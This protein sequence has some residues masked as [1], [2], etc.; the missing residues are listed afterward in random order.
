MEESQILHILKIR[1]LH[2]K[3]IAASNM[4]GF[5]QHVNHHYQLQL[6]NYPELYQWSIDH[7]DQ[8]WPAVWDYCQIQAALPYTNPYQRAAATALFEDGKPT[9]IW[10]PGARLNFAENCLRFRDDHPAIIFV[11]EN[12]ERQE[13]SYAALYQQVAAVAQGLKN[14]GIEA[15]DCVAG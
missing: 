9:T 14:A 8:F 10:F 13:L 4:T 7:A 11:S 1:P 3:A 6:K 12:G 15:T 2:K 5:M